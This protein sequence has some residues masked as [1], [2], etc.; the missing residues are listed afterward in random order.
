MFLL[1]ILVIYFGMELEEL[2]GRKLLENS[3]I[4][5]PTLEMSVS[6]SQFLG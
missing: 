6:F 5:C 3:K 4:C 1:A 2:A